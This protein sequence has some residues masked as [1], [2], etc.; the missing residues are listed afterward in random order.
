MSA[1]DLP[2]GKLRRR[3]GARRIVEESIAGLMSSIEEIGIINPIRVRPIEIFESGRTA[4]GWEI[5][6]GA[7]RFEAATRLNLPVVPCIVVHDDDLHA[8]LAMI[9]ENLCR[10]DLTPAQAAYQTAR[11]KEIYEDLHPETRHGAIGN[12]REKS[13]KFCDSTSNG[14]FTE[15][16]S[17]NTGKSE[18]AIQLDV[19]RGEALGDD[20]EAITGT[21]LDK[22]VELDAL[23]KM[24]PS[25]RAEIVSRAARGERVSAREHSIDRDL[26]IEAARNIAARLSEWC[27]PSEWDWLKSSLYTAGAKVVADA[28]VN[29]TGAG[30]PVIG[31]QWG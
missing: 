24:S 19:A 22:G 29:E 4:E 5:T 16:T 23:A 20:L 7:H 18:R 31:K 21:S 11:R 10:T 2:L 25:D 13:R 26:K 1:V 6:A 8:E 27:P 30:A 17:R 14:R 28:F 12:G 3:Q 15:D 9:D